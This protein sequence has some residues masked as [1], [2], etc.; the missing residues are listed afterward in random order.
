MPLA[1]HHDR[2]AKYIQQHRNAAEHVI[3]FIE[4]E[5]RVE[6]AHVLEIG[7]GEGGVL[8]AFLDRGC[9]VVGLDLSAEKIE[10]AKA[11]VPD[12][13]AD[14]RALFLAANIYDDNACER[15]GGPFDIVVMKDTIEHI[16]DQRRLLARTREFVTAEGVLF[17]G[18]PPWR[19]PYGGH[20]QIL[21]TKLGKLPYYHLL[22]RPI[23]IK[24]LQAMGETERRIEEQIEIVDTRISIAQME[25]YLHD[26]E[27]ETLQREFFLV[28]PI[29]AYK[30]G[31]KP[32][33]Q[34]PIVRS[35][36]WF[37]D[38]ITTTAY[39]LVRPRRAGSGL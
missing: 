25:R 1:F 19:M 29:Y 35:I 26:A 9:S 16:P 20:Q 17:V 21:D 37:R 31:L 14:G 39:Y 36:P 22:P 23:Y 28:N 5:V 4:R 32:R 8:E 30:F 7:C 24:A 10:H 18:F 2:T 13:I 6:G 15:L 3:P 34:L 33:R 38:F 27:W 12:A 11:A